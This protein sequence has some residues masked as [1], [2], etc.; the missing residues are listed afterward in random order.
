MQPRCRRPGT[1]L[2]NHNTAIK[3]YHK[4]GRPDTGNGSVIVGRSKT[5]YADPVRSMEF[6]PE[7][8]PG[9]ASET[10]DVNVAM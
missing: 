4:L 5:F 10:P 2:A 3:T 6:C 7:K 1:P 8:M 9:F